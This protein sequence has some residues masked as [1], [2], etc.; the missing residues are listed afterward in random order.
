MVMGDGL[1]TYRELLK[2]RPDASLE[3][4]R[5]AYDNLKEGLERKLE[6]VTCPHSKVELM[7]KVT[8]ARAAYFFLLRAAMHPQPKETGSESHWQSSSLSDQ[9]GNPDPAN[10]VRRQIARRI[11]ENSDGTLPPRPRAK[12]PA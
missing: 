2:V 4:L 9:P 10:R 7:K 8:E 11:M 6:G 1:E 12:R 3:E 5:A